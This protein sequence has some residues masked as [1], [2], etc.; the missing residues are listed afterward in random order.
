VPP[1]STALLI[2]VKRF[3][4]AK[5]RLQGTLSD[6]QRAGFARWMAARVIGAAGTLPVTVVCDD[7][8]VAEFA[9]D[10]GASIAFAPGRGLNGAIR[11]GLEALRR[12]GFERALVAHSDLPMVQDFSWLADFDGFTVVPDRRGDGTPVLG[13]VLQTGFR[14]AYGVGSFQRHLQAANATGFLV[15]T[16]ID[17]ALGFDVDVAADLDDAGIVVL[18]DG[19][20]WFAHR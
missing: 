15:R 4:E 2:P 17:D 10:R 18:A 5:Q 1:G 11:F 3:A 7:T 19:E 16:V 20:G 12:D 9:R 14:V 6:H 8:E 13:I